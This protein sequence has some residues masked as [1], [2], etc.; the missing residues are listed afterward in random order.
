MKQTGTSRIVFGVA[1]FLLSPAAFSETAA[2]FPPEQL[3]LVQQGLHDIY[4]MDYRRAERTFQSMV[5]SAPDDPTGYAYLAKTYWIEDL[6]RRQE[7]SIDR[8]AASNFFSENPNASSGGDA[9]LQAR[10]RQASTEALVRVRARLSKNP[11]DR[12]ALFVRSLV[13][14]SLASFELSRQKWWDAYRHGTRALRD[15]Q[16]LLR[17]DPG[18]PD[19]RLSLGVYDYVAGSL[20]WAFRWIAVLFGRPGS[21]ERG[22]QELVTAAEK[23]IL[24][25]DDARVILILLYMREKRYENAAAILD[26]LRLQYTGNYLAH[27]DLGG[28]ALLMDQPDKAIATYQE[29]LRQRDGGEPNY[30]GLERAVVCNRLG[31][32]FRQKGDLASSIDWLRRALAEPRLS[33]RSAVVARLEL[34]K[35]LDLMGARAEALENYR[36]V[37]AAEDFAASRSEARNL[38]RRPYKQ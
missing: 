33:A 32:A 38:L 16:E 18:F 6:S 3:A 15:D 7:L 31:V 35:S 9:G 8:F 21:K 23:G 25:A 22:R 12:A 29:I 17:R 10:F 14:Q 4:N 24:V 36:Q 19:A 13:Y 34:G 28:I 5:K 30:A 27:L 1:A 2:L 11:N 20:P 37:I 26:W